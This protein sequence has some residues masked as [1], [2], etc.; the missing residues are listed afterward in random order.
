VGNAP[1]NAA[2][3]VFHGRTDYAAN[4]GTE[5]NVERYCIAGPETLE[6]VEKGQFRVPSA[7]C[8]TGISNCASKIG[9]RQ[10]ADGLSK[11]YAVGERSI[12]P[13]HYESGQLHSDDWSM[14]VG[15]QDDLYRSAFYNPVKGTGF[16][17]F[18]DTPGVDLGN[19]F[20]S[21]HTGGCY[22]VFCDGSVQF[23]SY[24]IEVSVHWMNANRSD[25]GDGPNPAATAPCLQEALRI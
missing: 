16:V 22:F 4:S 2:S 10:I 17:P 5:S 12:D 21:A 3:S 7:K 20:G 24:S 1:R 15:I 25:G 6:E 23:V 14:Y 19:Y 13:L 18:Q 11:T 8:Y 9:Y